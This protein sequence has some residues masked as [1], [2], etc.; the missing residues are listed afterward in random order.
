MS[1]ESISTCFVTGHDFSHAEIGP[2]SAGLEPLLTSIGHLF[3]AKTIRQT[4]PSPCS[5]WSHRVAS[6]IVAVNFTSK[7][8]AKKNNYPLPPVSP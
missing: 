1:D 3:F 8:V 4:L 7:H 2:K 6:I 5:P